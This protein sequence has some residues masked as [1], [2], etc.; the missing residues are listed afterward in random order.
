MNDKD[1][2]KICNYLIT[3]D[4][5]E[6][7]LYLFIFALT[8]SICNIRILKGQNLDLLNNTDFFT[9]GYEHHNYLQ[10]LSNRIFAI[11][12]LYFL[13]NN[14]KTYLSTDYSNYDD[15]VDAWQNFIATFLTFYSIILSGSNIEL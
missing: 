11:G 6:S 2:E 14:Y 12:T 5:S 7:F 4:T 10:L 8:L 13:S 15:K 3:L 9:T 1:I